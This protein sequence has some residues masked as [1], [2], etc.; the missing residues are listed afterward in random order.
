M[1]D[2]DDSD[3]RKLCVDCIG[4]ERFAKWIRDN[5]FEGRC[6]LSELHNEPNAV[7]TVSAFA[8]EVDRFFRETYQL[9]EE[10]PHVYEES[11]KVWYEP[12]G[13]PYKDILIDELE[14][15]EAV[16]DAIAELL[17]DATDRDIMQGDEPFYDECN[18]YEAIATAESRSRANEEDYWYARRFSL[19]WDDFCKT[20]QFERRFF[21]TKELL[22]SL[23]GQPDEYQE[24]AVRPIYDL[25]AGSKIFRAR[26]LDDEFKEERLAKN[27]AAELGAPPKERARAG[28]MNVEYIPAFYA[29]FSED[30]AVAELRPSIGDQLAAGE[31]ILQRDIRVFDFTVFSK[32]ADEK[33]NEAF[34]HTRYEFITQMEDEISKPI[35]PFAK[36]REYIGTQMVAE[37]L[38][39]YFEC[40]AVI[41]RSSM[42]KDYKADNRNIVIFG[43]GA[44]F[45]GDGRMLKLSAHQIVDVDDVVYTTSVSPF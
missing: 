36:Q 4:D 17:P 27:P 41:Y 22:D 23:F 6:D 35:L 25:K 16:V 14:C 42:H 3:Q 2:N 29:A 9:G 13:E 33:K 38:R 8:E 24:G 12:E 11:D 44:E 18:S 43:R 5:G 20:V 15:D 1:S 21:K 31:F 45:V 30:T 32:V 26:L 34:G 37:Y 39:E 7:V 10:L 28:R 40:D 19:Q